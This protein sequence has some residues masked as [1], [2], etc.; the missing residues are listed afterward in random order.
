MTMEVDINCDLGEGF[1]RYNVCDEESVIP[2]IS[3]CNVA[4][5]F[6]AGD[7]IVMRKTVS[8]ALMNNVAVGAHPSYPD[9]QGFGRRFMK[10]TGEE[11]ESMVMYQ[12]GALKAI[13]MAEGGQLF[14]VK[15][16]GALYNASADDITI[17][18]SIARSIKRLDEKL[19]FTGLPDS[20]H[21]RACE[22]LDLPFRPEGFGDRKYQS[23]GRLVSR[24]EDGAVL[25]TSEAI[26]NQILGIIQDKQVNTKDGNT[27]QLNADTICLHGDNPDLPAVLHYMICELEEKK[28]SIKKYGGQ[29]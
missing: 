22:E 14:H 15:P 10:M 23:N 16:H 11:L 29:A 5:G 19:Y 26:T 1:G 4:C 20:S 8:L 2:L 25:R 6:H 13:V 27:I 3:S 21:Q 18:R 7:P 12:V 28:I 17:A 9:L 24:S